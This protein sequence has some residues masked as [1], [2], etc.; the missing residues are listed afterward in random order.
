MYGSPPPP[1]HQ[2]KQTSSYWIFAAIMFQVYINLHVKGVLFY[3]TYMIYNA[4]EWK[5]Q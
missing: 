4:T 5:W 3:Y 2:K 1:H